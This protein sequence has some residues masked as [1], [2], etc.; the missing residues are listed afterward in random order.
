MK[1]DLNQIKAKMRRNELKAKKSLLFALKMKP[2]IKTQK[3]LDT[4]AEIAIEEG[5]KL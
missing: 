3:D 5:L 2:Y 1:N 4:F